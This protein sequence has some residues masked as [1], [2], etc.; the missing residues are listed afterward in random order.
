MLCGCGKDAKDTELADRL[1]AVTTP[2]AKQEVTVERADD[3]KASSATGDKE[4][5]SAAVYD[6]PTVQ[7]GDAVIYDGRVMFRVYG[8]SSVDWHGLFGEFTTGHEPYQPNDIYTFD[9]KDPDGGIAK[10][11]EDYGY[12]MMYL[13][14]GTT[15]Y[16]Q[17]VTG[18]DDDDTDPAQVYKR[19]LPDGDEQK[20]CPGEI[21]GFSPDGKHFTVSYYTTDP[22]VNYF[23][24]YESGTEDI[25]TA[26]Y[27]TSETVTFLGMDNDNAFLLEQNEDS[28]FSVLQLSKSGEIYT[29]ADPDLSQTD[30]YYEGMNPSFGG[31]FS[32]DGDLL[33]FSLDFYE[34]TGHFYSMSV[35]ITVPICKGGD[36]PG[37]VMYEADITEDTKD[38]DP[39][40]V[41]PDE[42]SDID[43]FP[44]PDGPGGIADVLQYFETFDEGIFYTVA[45]GHRD[46]FE[47]IG[48]RESYYL[49]NY[50]Y[51]FLPKGEDEPVVIH[52]MFEPLGARGSLDE[53]EYF[54]IQPTIYA[55]AKFLEDDK[56]K[57]CGMYYEIV[58]IQGPEAPIETSGLFKMAPFANKVYYEYLRDEDDLYGGFVVGG[59]D[60]LQKLVDS[61]PG[62]QLVMPAE[63]DST[64]NLKFD[65]DV[66][67]DGPEGV[68]CCHIGFD[69][70]GN[71][72][73]IRPVMW[74]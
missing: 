30:G 19:V 46:P 61:F 38:D 64:G 9:P 55:Y 29:L 63:S 43:D 41:L 27:E 12:G 52:T 28:S 60:E 39:E 20:I 21:A 13:M 54:E 16:S 7:A 70:K 23:R 51:C 2:A 42:L 73:Y 57:L 69:D 35:E 58:D 40:A 32:A 22:Y 18:S 5:E 1:T 3:L 59:I 37:T 67:F 14:D 10:L 17:R 33:S 62:K 34:G 48:W 45:Q 65:P 11:C 50:R 26:G 44:D 25:D 72:S 47:D 68:Y 6:L 56:G 4:E 31:N 71:V 36:D 74:D 24:I 66:T 8:Y 15:L 49:L 53:Y